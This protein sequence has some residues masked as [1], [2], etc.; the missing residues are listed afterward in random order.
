LFFPVDCRR[1]CCCGWNKGCAVVV[2][3]RWFQSR[4]RYYVACYQ[5]HTPSDIN[6][7]WIILT[8]RMDLSKSALY[9]DWGDNQ[10]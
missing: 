4:R 7:S 10:P 9:S 8:T 5:H 3:L 1:C 2:W 6:Q